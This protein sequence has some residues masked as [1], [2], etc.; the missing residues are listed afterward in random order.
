M[1]TT[2]VSQGNPLKWVSTTRQQARGKDRE[3]EH[4]VDY[5]AGPS[6]PVLTQ[7]RRHPR[8]EGCSAVS[9]PGPRPERHPR[10]EDDQLMT[11]SCRLPPSVFPRPPLLSCLHLL[12]RPTE[13][14]GPLEPP[15]GTPR[16]RPPGPS[17]AHTRQDPRRED[18]TRCRPHGWEN[19]K[20][21]ACRLA[22]RDLA[23]RF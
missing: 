11:N 15:V 19:T 18:P 6:Q 17:A 5:G 21:T 9:A 2:K 10:P 14:T 4:P 12:L 23:G 7:G 22:L 13:A 3:E 16:P 20:G 1:S 8:P